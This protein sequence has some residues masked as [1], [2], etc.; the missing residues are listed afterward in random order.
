MGELCVARNANYINMYNGLAKQY[1]WKEK[2]PEV[3]EKTAYFTTATSWIVH[4][5]TGNWIMNKQTAGFYGQYN[6]YT[7]EWDTDILEKTGLAPAK[8]PP[9]VEGSD[10]VGT[11]TKEAAEEWGPG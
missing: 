8:F 6:A 7:R 4:E 1:W 2:M 11:V 3:Y 9:L 10:I 5:L